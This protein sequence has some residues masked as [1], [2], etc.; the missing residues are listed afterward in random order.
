MD[1]GGDVGCLDSLELVVMMMLCL[2]L[3]E[4]IIAFHLQ[5]YGQNCSLQDEQFPPDFLLEERGD[6]I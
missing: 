3:H 1:D 2:S 5:A 6:L 4:E